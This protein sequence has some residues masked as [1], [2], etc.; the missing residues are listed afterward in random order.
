M[1]NSFKTFCVTAIA[2]LLVAVSTPV[3]ANY[4]K[5][6][7]QNEIN[8]LRRIYI[9]ILKKTPAMP[10]LAQLGSGIQRALN[11]AES[12]KDAGNYKTCVENMKT[13]ISIVEGYAR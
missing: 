4:T 13:H 7:C 12:N 8:N 3:L 10:P 9:V 1:K 5:T 2:V 6:D 11:Q